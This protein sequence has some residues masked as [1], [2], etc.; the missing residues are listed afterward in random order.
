MLRRRKAETRYAPEQTSSWL[1]RLAWQMKHQ[2]QTIFSLE[3][4]QP[5]WLMK[6]WQRRLYYG[7]I[8]G[9]ICGLFVGLAALGTVLS[10]PFIVLMTA[11]ISGLLF[12]WGSEPETETKSTKTITHLWIRQSLAPSLETGGRIAIAAGVFVACLF[13]PTF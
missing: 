10:F 3:Q 1:S 8:T 6:K 11:L 2:S 9:P 4:M 5:G 7:L 12:G 13:F